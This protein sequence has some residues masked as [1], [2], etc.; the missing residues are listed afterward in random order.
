MEWILRSGVCSPSSLGW[1][2]ALKDMGFK[3]LGLDIK[4]YGRL[5]NEIDDFKQ[6]KPASE[7]NEKEILDTLINLQ[8]KI[9]Y[10]WIISGPEN[11]IILLAK[12]EKLL[13]ENG[14]NIF[15]PDYNSLITCTDKGL[16]NFKVKGLIP[17]PKILNSFEEIDK[18]LTNKLIL[19]PRKGRGSQ[20]IF[21]C[22]KENV[23]KYLELLDRDKRED[24]IIQEYIDG[25]EYSVDLLY[26]MNGR[27]LNMVVRKRIEV[28][29][30][31]SI[32]TQT[33]KNPKI[34]YKLKSYIDYL[35]KMFLFRG[36]I[37]IQFIH[38]INKD[39]FYL[40]DINPRLGGASI[41]SYYATKSFRENIK[42]LLKG[43]YESIKPNLEPD[44][45]NMI[46]YRFYE[47]RFYEV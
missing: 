18:C 20:N 24:F 8:K 3:V 19:K 31:I 27:K 44:Y 33:E 38:D 46:L 22:T 12:Y 42:N 35:D 39:E 28:D 5:I 43:N 15:H 29:S 32:L 9:K 1:I 6:I 34:F 10:K 25:Y 30:G 16:V 41:V 14:I 40:T 21:I 37:C 7:Q 13:N 26:D 4:S 23:Y 11:E 17:V 2:K 45:K 36:G 47:D